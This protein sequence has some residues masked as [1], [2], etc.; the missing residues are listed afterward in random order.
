[1]KGANCRMARS[2]SP[3]CP[4]IHPCLVTIR[5]NMNKMIVANLVHRPMRSVISVIAI[6]VEVTLILVIVGLS[7]GMLNDAA[8]R[9]RGVGADVTVQMPGASALAGFNGSPMPI[10]IADVIRKQPHVAVVS[11]VVWQ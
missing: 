3:K 4:V 8:E 5:S 6:A 2:L 11:P 10:K 9:T 1:M 7:L